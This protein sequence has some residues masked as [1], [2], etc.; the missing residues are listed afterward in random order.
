[1][2]KEDFARS[3]LPELGHILVQNILYAIKIS[4]PIESVAT[5]RKAKLR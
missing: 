1:L 2:Q 3:N 5:V 4:E